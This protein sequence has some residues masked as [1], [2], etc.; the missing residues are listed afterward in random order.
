MDTLI[1][2]DVSFIATKYEEATGVVADAEFSRA[3]GGKADIGIGFMKGGVHTQETLKFKKSS[4]GMLSKLLPKLK[5]RYEELDLHAF[6]NYEGTRIQWIKGLM[7]IQ[8]WANPKEPE[9]KYDYYGVTVGDIRVAL[10]SEL[11]YFVSGFGNVIDTSDALIANVGI[12]VRALIKVLWRVEATK[13]LVSV[14]YVIL[15][16][17]LE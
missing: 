3:E 10:V 7:S 16:E 5:N 4:V 14:P 2:L 8:S 13:E 15:E 6:K 12:P 17:T 1:Y 9:S 11:G